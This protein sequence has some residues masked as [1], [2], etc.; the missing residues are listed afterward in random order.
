MYQAK[1]RFKKKKKILSGKDT[2][3][4]FYS[5]PIGSYERRDIK[6]EFGQKEKNKEAI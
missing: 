2:A 6:A 4:F 5:E 3:I 1:E